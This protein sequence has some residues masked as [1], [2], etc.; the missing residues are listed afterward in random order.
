M[1]GSILFVEILISCKQDLHRDLMGI[2]LSYSMEM[3]M[4]VQGRSKQ[5][6]M[7]VMLQMAAKVFEPQDCEPLLISTILAGVPHDAN[8]RRPFRTVRLKELLGKY[9]VHERSHIKNHLFFT[10]V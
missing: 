1:I 2:P 7:V 10:N 9:N 8:Q 3:P 6:T 5:L 4:V